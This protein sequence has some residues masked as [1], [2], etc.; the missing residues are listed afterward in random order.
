MQKFKEFLHALVRDHLSGSSKIPATDAKTWI[1]VIS[2]LSQ[3][4]LTRV[5]PHH[6]V[7]WSDAAEKIQLL[8]ITLD[9]LLRASE[10][11]EGLYDTDSDFAVQ[12]F[13]RLLDLNASLCYWLVVEDTSVLLTP[14]QLH[15]KVSHVL[16][17]FLRS[18]GNSNSVSNEFGEQGW[19]LM[20]SIITESLDF[21][22][23]SC[24]N[25]N[26]EGA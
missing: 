26:R 10:R 8:D 22:H 19:R 4:L 3:H 9:V 24:P 7:T 17:G 25:L 12:M 21:A 5:P 1:S 16:M 14:G 11:V 6:E 23:G 2:N 15:A 13:A 20:R 18:L